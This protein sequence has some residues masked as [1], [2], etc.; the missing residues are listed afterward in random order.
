MPST[1]SSPSTTFQLS[2]KDAHATRLPYSFTLMIAAACNLSVC[3][4][5]VVRHSADVS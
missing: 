5:L 2:A 4:Y 3:Y 1:S